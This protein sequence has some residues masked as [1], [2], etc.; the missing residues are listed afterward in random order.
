[1][2]IITRVVSPRTF[3]LIAG[4][5]LGASASAC[6][7]GPKN[8]GD[9]TVSGGGEEP[10]CEDGEQKLSDDGCNTCTCFDG[11]WGCTLKLCDPGTTGAPNDT[12]EPPAQCVDGDQKPAEDGCNTCTCYGGEW[13][14]TEKGCVPGTTGEP[15]DTEEPPGECVEGEEKPAGDGCNTCLCYEGAWACTMS[16]CEDTEGGDTENGQPSCGD[17]VVEPGEACDDGNFVDGDGCAANCTLEGAPGI[18][19]CADPVASDPFNYVD[20]QIVGDQLVV[21]IEHGG[22]C[23]DH[24]YTYCWNGAF[25]ESDPVQ[26]HTQIAHESNDDPCDAWLSVQAAFDLVPLK[27]AWQQSYQQQ[28]GQITVHLANYNGSPLSY[29]F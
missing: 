17:G 13:A 4:A 23:A 18:E 29:S 28:S 24:L 14:C 21:G 7:W 20:A 10:V 11:D 25:L 9:E 5:L 3:L 16:A 15:N 22:G 2:T 12:E 26:V 19:L 1:M 8:I 6:D 27:Q